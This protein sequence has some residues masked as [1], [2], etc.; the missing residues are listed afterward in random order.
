MTKSASSASAEE[1]STDDIKPVKTLIPVKEELVLTN[2]I[3]KIAAMIFLN[4]E[5]HPRIIE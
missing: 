5:Y 3:D 4:I 1:T 2:T